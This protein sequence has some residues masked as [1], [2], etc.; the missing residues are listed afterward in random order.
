R[1][2]AVL[3]ELRHPGIVRYVS[4]GRSP[5]G[6]HYIVMEW[7]D[8]ED[9]QQRLAERP[10]TPAESLAVVHDAAAALAVAHARGLV[11]RDVK[12]S[13]IFLVGRDVRRVRL[14]D[15]GIARLVDE[16][17]VLT[18]QGDILGSPGYMAPEQAQG[19]VV[20]ARTDVF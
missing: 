14:L 6:D 4:H 15:F 10:L 19:R 12:P 2:S 1:E 13:N 3:A 20:S 9:L 5:E 16:A 11:H 7:L 18:R 17:K 8:G